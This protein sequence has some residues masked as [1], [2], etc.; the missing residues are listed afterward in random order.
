V[1]KILIQFLESLLTQMRPGPQPSEQVEL[2]PSVGISVPDADKGKAISSDDRCEAPVPGPAV[3]TLLALLLRALGFARGQSPRADATEATQATFAVQHVA[4]NSPIRSRVKRSSFWSRS[5]RKEF[6]RREI[7]AMQDLISPLEPPPN[8]DPIQWS[9]DRARRQLIGTELLLVEPTPEAISQARIL[10]EEVTRDVTRIQRF[11]TELDVE[12]R[13]SYEPPLIE[14]QQQLVRV[15]RLLL[16]AKRMQWARIR[17]V[18]ALVQTYTSSGKAR[19]WNPS[20]KTWTLE[21]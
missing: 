12:H 2:E 1:R 20:S 15:A 6:S 18:G 3:R 8:V 7:N 11:A 10:L 9:L 16:G 5:G 19:L 21:M 14:F 17:W 4:A 13:A